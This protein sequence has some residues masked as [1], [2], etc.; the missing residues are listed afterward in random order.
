[1]AEV[2]TITEMRDRLA[3]CKRYYGGVMPLDAALV[4]YGYFGALIE[5]GL[6]SPTDHHELTGYLPQISNNP[7][8]G[9]FLGW[10][11][12]LSD[13]VPPTQQP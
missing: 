2:P 4:W 1:M 11:R 3:E 10:D 9:V 7:V 8:S 6:L 13:F 12:D 5:W